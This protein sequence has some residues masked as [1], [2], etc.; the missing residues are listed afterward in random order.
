MND[1]EFEALSKEQLIDLCL[2]KDA[3]YKNE[4][5]EIIFMGFAS[6]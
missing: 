1:K 3:G 5:T 2:V 6:V 4:I